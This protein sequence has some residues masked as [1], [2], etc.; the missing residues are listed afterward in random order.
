MGP[1]APEAGITA[2]LPLNLLEKLAKK[3]LSFLAVFAS[4]QQLICTLQQISANVTDNRGGFP[5]FVLSLM[6]KVFIAVAQIKILLKTFFY[7]EVTSNLKEF[8]LKIRR[9]LFFSDRKNYI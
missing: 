3:S 1:N 7:L 8:Y 5:D 6:L 9:K 4:L 2:S